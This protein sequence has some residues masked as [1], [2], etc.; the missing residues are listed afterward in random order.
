MIG[1]IGTNH[2]IAPLE[3]R[4]KIAKAFA[5]LYLR[6]LSFPSVLLSTCNRVEWYFSSPFPA[7]THQE[8]VAMVRSLIEGVEEGISF[9][10]LPSENQNPQVEMARAMTT[11]LYTFFGSECCKHLER[12]VTGLDSLFVG[13]TQIQGQVKTAYLQAQKEG[14]LSTELHLLF[15]K[16]LHTGKVVRHRFPAFPLCSET[17]TTK[18]VETI[19]LLPH[20]A[21]VLLVGASMINREI[22]SKLNP[23]RLTITNRTDS[24]AQ[25]IASSLGCTALPWS[26][27]HNF[28]C[29][30]PCVV[31]ATKSTEFLHLSSQEEASQLVIDLGL[32]RNINPS[33]ASQSRKIITL[34]FFLPSAQGPRC[35]ELEGVVEARAHRDYLYIHARH[36]TSAC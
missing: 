31:T 20:D 8:I 14:R 35:Q 5:S 25:V 34:D 10:P 7:Q 22:A 9:Q 1:V 11:C 21:S 36:A 4:E 30:Y 16:A 12:V 18:V 15:Q 26:S 19:D 33:L 17:L 3:I 2:S 28:W 32:P 13:E 27:L 6:P 23:R 29:Q 24:S